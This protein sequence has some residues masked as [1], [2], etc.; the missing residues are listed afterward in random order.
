M[1]L[2]VGGTPGGQVDGPPVVPLNTADAYS[3][4]L[5]FVCP[6]GTVKSANVHRTQDFASARGIKRR[7]ILPPLFALA[8]GTGEQA[9]T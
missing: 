3:F 7:R 9:G 5:Q 4:S 6:A 2:L 1:K 8:V